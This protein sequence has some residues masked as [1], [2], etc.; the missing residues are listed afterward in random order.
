M[1]PIIAKIEKL[2]NKQTNKKKRSDYLALRSGKLNLR[3][4][5]VNTFDY[6]HTLP[7]LVLS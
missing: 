7:T 5:F 2:I 6:A 4:D 3:P 1:H